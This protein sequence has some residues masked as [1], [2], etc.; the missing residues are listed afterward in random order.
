MKSR[1]SIGAAFM[2]I[3]AISLAGLA[4]AASEPRQSQKAVSEKKGAVWAVFFFTNDCPHCTKTRNLI[5]KLKKKHTVRIKSFNIDN[6]KD[7]AIY[8]R[9]ESIHARGAFSVP[10]VMVG[11][12]LLIGEKQ[13]SDNLEKIVKKLARS[14][15]AKMPYLGS[16]KLDE[17]AP[18]QT[19]DADCDHCGRRGPPTIGEELRKV[20]GFLNK[21]W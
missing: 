18:K 9:L 10:L 16:G 14:G 8:R 12:S 15:G 11:E 19:S 6:D 5:E 4:L 21:I 17:S 7:Y 20:K 2:A 1:C 13:I 3:L